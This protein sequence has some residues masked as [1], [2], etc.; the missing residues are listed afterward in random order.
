MATITV[1]NLNDSGAGSLR[2]AVLDAQDGDLITFDA[3]LSGGTINLASEIFFD[4][5]LYDTDGFDL[6][7]DGDLNDDGVADITLDAGGNGRAVHLGNATFI[8]GGSNNNWMDIA[9]DGLNITN[10]VAANGGG[11]FVGTQNILNFKNGSLTNNEATAD[12]GSGG[13]VFFEV[14]AG[15]LW[16]TVTYDSNRAAFEG[17]AVYVRTGAQAGPN[18]ANSTFSNNSAGDQATFT[19]DGGA[20]YWDDLSGSFFSNNTVSNN[21]AGDQGGGLYIGQ[22]SGIFARHNTIT[23]NSAANGG[24]GI[25]I[26]AIDKAMAA[27]FELDESVVFGNTGSAD[28]A[29][30]GSSAGIIEGD[31]NYIASGSVSGVGNTVNGSDPKLGALKDNGGPT[32]THLPAP[33]SPLVDA[34]LGIG[35][36][37]D[38]RGEARPGTSLNDIG[39]VERQALEPDPDLFDLLGRVLVDVDRSGG[40]TSADL[41]FVDGATFYL[42]SNNNGELD[43]GERTAV[44][45]SGGLWEFD[46]G[47]DQNS[48]YVI[49]IDLPDGYEL[50]GTLAR[51]GAVA[52]QDFLSFTSVTEGAVRIAIGDFFIALANEAPVATDDT[53]ATDEGTAI[54]ILALTNDTDADEDT[55]TITNV[56]DPTNG[57]AEI[58]D[59]GQSIIYTPDDDF[60]GTETFTYTI[61]DGSLTDTATVTITVEEVNAVLSIAALDADKAEGNA[62]TTPFTFTVTRTGALNDVVS[63]SYAV[64]P[65]GSDPAEAQDFDGAEFPSGTLSFGAGEVTQTITIDV[66]TDEIFAG[67]EGFTVTLSDPVNAEIGTPSAAAGEIDNDDPAPQT[68]AQVDIFVKDADKAEGDVGLTAF[69]FDVVRTGMI[70]R[71]ATVAWRVV[72][73]QDGDDENIFDFNVITPSAT[74][75]FLAGETVET[76]EVLVSGDFDPEADEVFEVELFAPSQVNIGENGSAFGVIRNDD[77]GTPP[78][79]LSTFT[80]AA[81]DA[82]KAEGDTGTTTFT[83]TVTRSGDTSGAATLDFDVAGAGGNGADADDFGGTL[84]SGQVSFADGESTATLTVDVTGDTDIEADE[85]FTV[86]LS[87]A[88]TGSITGPTANGTILNDD[89]DGGDGGDTGSGGAV[90]IDVT[91]QWVNGGGAS[92]GFQGFI[93]LTNDTGSGQIEF[94]FDLDLTAFSIQSFWASGLPVYP[95]FDQANGIV[96]LE[97]TGNPWWQPEI[98]DGDSF[99]I[100]FV[101][102]T[103]DAAAI[104]AVQVGETALETFLADTANASLTFEWG[105]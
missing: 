86:T 54:E 27:A 42:D 15:G 29:G 44:S 105:V 81:D 20:V 1:T 18:F 46:D 51:N 35:F 28:F 14:G 96:D 11:I 33:D 56:S 84:P 85:G 40:L 9:F 36:T 16:D 89:D 104:A 41:L 76:I 23:E 101:A 43:D 92:A 68:G 97:P 53:E 21:S 5:T 59:S 87:N 49:R 50:T 38:Q 71:T 32:F 100:D 95:D 63:V 99:T 80:V 74:V 57:T 91:N 6:A 31:Y 45:D 65:S 67:D 2:Q 58:T 73:P 94:D 70:D 102:L 64:T 26:E 25:Y 52:G 7:I 82:A 4:P 90:S 72:L 47:F 69:T 39:S 22:D 79:P 66:F 62:G 55:L 19:G 37:V 10:G 61:S 78:P 34:V 83:F 60:F 12:A 75:E 48:T 88:S 30:P 77:D 13:A 93:E 3:S 98:A 8:G 17:G 103:T 24:S